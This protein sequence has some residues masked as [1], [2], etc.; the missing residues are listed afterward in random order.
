M[1]ANAR[2]YSVNGAVGAAWRE[3][4]AWVIERAQVAVEVVDYPAPQPLDALWRRTDMAC[5]LMCGYPW[6][7]WNEPATRPHALAAPVPAAA[8]FEGRGA[9]CTDIVVP[10]DSALRTVDDLRDR[11]LAWTLHDSQSGYQALRAYF[12]ARAAAEATAGRL[13]ASTVGPL[14]TPRRVIDA[15]L[16]GEADAGPLDAYWHELLRQ[17][18]PVLAG[19]LRVLAS[20]PL[21]PMPLFVAAAGTSAA[22]RE[23]LTASLLEAGAAPELAGL[24]EQLLLR[25]FVRV[26]PAD[27]AVLIR[28]AVDADALGYRSLQ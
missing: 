12:A 3:L 5:A 16:G 7:S 17:H 22:V 24:R 13:F 11:R 6:A 4:L 21:T 15:L 28:R 1:F 25:G 19:R 27:Y 14:I 8:R 10:A 23:R 20:T 2:M 26:D 9:Y 18:E